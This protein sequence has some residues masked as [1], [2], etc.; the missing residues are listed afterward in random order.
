MR[1]GP[2]PLLLQL[3]SQHTEAL[4]ESAGPAASPSVSHSPPPGSRQTCACPPWGLSASCPAACQFFL[5]HQQG[6]HPPLLRSLLQSSLREARLGG[7]G[8]HSGTECPS[9]GPSL[10]HLCC[11]S[12]PQLPPWLRVQGSSLAARLMRPEPRTPGFLPSAVASLAFLT[13]SRKELSEP[14]VN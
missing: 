4:R 6:S 1:A 2:E 9:P 12:S 5:R 11:S 14:S 7:P 10:P 8:M 13:P 3:A